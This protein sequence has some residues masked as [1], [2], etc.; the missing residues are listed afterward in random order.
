LLY[1]ALSGSNNNNNGNS[2]NDNGKPPGGSPRGQPP[3]QLPPTPNPPVPP[4]LPLL[5]ELTATV[6]VY[7]RD[8]VEKTT[9]SGIARANLPILLTQREKLE[10]AQ[11]GLSIDTQVADFAQPRLVAL[12]PQYPSLASNPNLILPGWKFRLN[13]PPTTSG[14]G[15]AI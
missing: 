8:P 3:V 4:T 2:S 11:S 7:G 6:G 10:A 1:T 13:E 9:L 15:R 14:P 12:N 5:P